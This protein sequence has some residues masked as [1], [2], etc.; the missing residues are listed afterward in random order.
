MLETKELPKEFEVSKADQIELLNKSLQFFKEKD[1]FNIDD[2]AH[3]V[4]AQPEVIEKFHQ[5]KREY[6]NQSDI[7]IDNRFEIPNPLVK[8][9]NVPIGVSSIWIKKFK[10]SLP[11][12]VKT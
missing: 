10:S 12:T 11:V 3:E 8:N 1:T 5:Y 7:V 9:S 2:F 6:E 4:I